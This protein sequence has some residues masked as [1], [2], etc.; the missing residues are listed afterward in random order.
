M[1]KP[2]TPPAIDAAA[3]QALVAEV[4]RRIRTA[5]VAAPAQA[6]APGPAVAAPAARLTDRVITLASLD[7]IPA[8]AR[9]VAIDAKAVVTPAAVDRARERGIALTRHAAQAAVPRR[10]FMIAQAACRG[11]VSARTAAIARTVPGAAQLP[12]SGLADVV[13]ALA[14]HASRDAARGVLLTGTP[15]VAVVLANR[16]ASLRAVT[17]R[18]AATLA[19][20]AAETAANLLVVDPAAFA[21]STLERFC[22]EFHRAGPAAV[23]AELTAAPP[24][25]GCTSHTH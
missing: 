22:A 12:A 4:V 7:R 1:S 3:I 17:A 9:E 23:P 21:G 18:D 15:A 20:V 19:A 10:P 11:D 24:G 2:T 16:S 14:S 8:G 13:A 5:G 6:T 25:C